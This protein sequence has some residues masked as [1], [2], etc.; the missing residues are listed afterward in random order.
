[1]VLVSKN[2][3]H[4]L[5][6]TLSNKGDHLCLTGSESVMKQNTW[7]LNGYR[8]DAQINMAH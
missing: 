7:C 4:R 1:M 8:M 3:S 2:F 6:Q 5:N